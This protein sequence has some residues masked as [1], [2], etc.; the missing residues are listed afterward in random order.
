MA[1]AHEII[2]HASHNMDMEA[3]ETEENKMKTNSMYPR[4]K[5]K[6]DMLFALRGHVMPLETRLEQERVFL[7]RCSACREYHCIHA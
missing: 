7:E 2:G 4:N 1:R 6:N 5:K 3:M